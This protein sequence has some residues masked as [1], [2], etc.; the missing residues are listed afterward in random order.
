[1]R[2][3]GWVALSVAAAMGLFA[4]HAT[5][6]PV[7][8][9]PGLTDGRTVYIELTDELEQSGGFR[10]AGRQTYG[11]VQKTAVSQ[12][13]KTKVELTY[14]RIA[15]A[16][17]VPQAVDYDSDRK[18]QTGEAAQLD[19]V[20]S[21]M[22]GKTISIEIGA[23]G[24]ATGMSGHDKM[25][26]AI[27]RRAGASAQWMS[28]RPMLTADVF[29]VQFWDKP[30]VLYPN[31]EVRPGDTWTCSLDAALP[32]VGLVKYQYDCTLKEVT[33]R[34]E[35][36][37]PSAALVEFTGKIV[38]ASE[39]AAPLGSGPMKLRI[40]SGKMKGTA[41]FDVKLGEFTTQMHETE[42]VIA[43]TLPSSAPAS[44]PDS[45]SITQKSK[46]VLR[47][48]T[49]EQRE[50]QKRESAAKSGAASKRADAPTTNKAGD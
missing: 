47:V 11:V 37:G 35:D 26:E 49:P 29:R 38:M 18:E 48:L 10:N 22:I 23:D 31:K 25:L 44:Q 45:L 6:Q 27:D 2:A 1:M 17:S 5:A 28:L 16:T 12:G 41:L 36:S 21:A 15:I 24:R 46:A 9:K 32:I 20:F 30:H 19:P 43:G 40:E 3:S 39:P 4:T 42:L 14:D 7:L 8:L 50:K 33:R 34:P 13:G